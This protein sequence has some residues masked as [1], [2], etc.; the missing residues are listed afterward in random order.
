MR[1]AS[2]CAT[3]ERRS[4]KTYQELLAEY[5]EARARAERARAEWDKQLPT[6]GIRLT[7][8]PETRAAYEEVVAATESESAARKALIDYRGD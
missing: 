5:D 4:V 1:D 8:H 6:E 2:R 3:K 7:T